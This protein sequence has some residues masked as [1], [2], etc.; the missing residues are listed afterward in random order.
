M[1]TRIKKEY[2]MATTKVTRYD[3]ATQRLR[4]LNVN[5]IG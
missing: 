4:V 3:I 1:S 2:L 5:A